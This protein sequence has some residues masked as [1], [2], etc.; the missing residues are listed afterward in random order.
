MFVRS[1]EFSLSYPL[2]EIR[3]HP[4][5][6]RL[7]L[8]YLQQQLQMISSADAL[9]YLN[10]NTFHHTTTQAAAHND[11]NSYQAR[12]HAAT[13]FARLHKDRTG[14]S[15]DPQQV[16]KVRGFVKHWIGSVFLAS[17]IH[18]FT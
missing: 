4:C 15:M 10:T 8:S 7:L 5:F 6:P 13:E 17:I 3:H 1:K 2:L 12:I 14:D 11:N 18:A 9:H 16:V